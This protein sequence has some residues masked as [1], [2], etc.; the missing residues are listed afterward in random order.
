MLYF[1]KNT[2]PDI[3][4]KYRRFTRNIWLRFLERWL[5]IW[6]VK[7]YFLLSRAMRKIEYNNTMLTLGSLQAS[8]LYRYLSLI[9]LQQSIL[10]HGPRSKDHWTEAGLFG[11]PRVQFLHADNDD[12]DQTVLIRRLIWAFPGRTC[13]KVFS[14]VVAH[15]VEHVHISLSISARYVQCTKT[16]TFFFQLIYYTHKKKKK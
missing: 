2:K 3:S 6:N 1:F 7:P 11:S 10:N 4:C 16:P 14:Q 15:T 13:Q 12:S 8:C 9:K 5:I